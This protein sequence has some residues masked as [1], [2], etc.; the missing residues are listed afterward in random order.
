[1]SRT[2]RKTDLTETTTKV[3]YI[4]DHICGLNRRYSVE[5]YMQPHNEVAYANAVAEHNKL[6]RMLLNSGMQPHY[7]TLRAPYWAEY[8]TVIRTKLVYDYD[9]EVA[10][11]AKEYDKSKRDC[12][13]YETGRNTQFKKHC[14]KDLRHKNKE[15]LSKILKD[16]ESWEQKPFPDTYMGKQYVWDYW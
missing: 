11:A 16:D 7:K 15:V 5:R 12:R 10:K 14:A 8:T 3:E 6:S 13:Y 4:N 9:E 2:Y 1:M